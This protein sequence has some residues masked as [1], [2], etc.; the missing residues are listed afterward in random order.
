M[1]N[2]AHH[3][4]NILLVDDDDVATEGVQRSL[5]KSDVNFHAVTAEDGVEA[6]DI[7]RGT[8]LQ[9]SISAP[10]LVLLD[11]NMPRM[12]GFT[13]LEE[14]R[15]DKVLHQTV[16]FVLTTSSRDADRSASYQKH[17]A[18]YMVKSEVG[19]QF[20]KLAAL[21]TSYG[22]SIALPPAE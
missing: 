3:M 16:V 22:Q 11:L 17:I 10:M 18:G 13:F 4:I 12:D 1:S 9:K 15:S 7:L 21:L 8:H 20:S 5:R 19:P 14:V 6:L 2:P